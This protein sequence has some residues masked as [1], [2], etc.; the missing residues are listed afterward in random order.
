[1]TLTERRIT[2]RD[3]LKAGAAG[4]VG[5]YLARPA[6]AALEHLD[7]TT[8]NWLT[9]SDHYAND[10]LAAVKKA[11]AIQAEP[12]VS[13]RTTSL[14]CETSFSTF[15]FTVFR[16]SFAREISAEDIVYGFFAP[17]ARPAIAIRS[18]GWFSAM[19]LPLYFG[20]ASACH[21]VGFVVTYFGL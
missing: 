20:S 7:A 18:V 10:Q 14:F 1:M 5:L 15:G 8:L 4:T 13:A 2:R 3:L 11:I 9:W 17:V 19:T 21:D 12:S 6:S 16:K